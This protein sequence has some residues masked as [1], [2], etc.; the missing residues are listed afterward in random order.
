MTLRW[1]RW[2]NGVW[3]MNPFDL[4]FEQLNEL[5]VPSDNYIID[6]SSVKFWTYY[7]WGHIFEEDF[8]NSYFHEIMIYYECPSGYGRQ[9]QIKWLRKRGYPFELQ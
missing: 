6:E 7:K 2:M 3:Y 5:S 4:T 1:A 9:K 8:F